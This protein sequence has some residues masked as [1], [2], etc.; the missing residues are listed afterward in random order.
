MLTTFDY[1]CM[2]AQA[3][4]ARCVLYC[5]CQKPYDEDRAMIACDRCS[6]WYH[7]SCL[8]LPEPEKH[9]EDCDQVLV[10]EC[11]ELGE[12]I[13]PKCRDPE[14]ETPDGS[15]RHELGSER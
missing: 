13:C 8:D 3:L 6:E 4:R 10:Q 12:F 9:D 15:Q 14:E 7:F 5:V 1:D 2:C 11:H